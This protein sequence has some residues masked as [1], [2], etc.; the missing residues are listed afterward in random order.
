MTDE[1]RQKLC[2]RLR[3]N[4]FDMDAEEIAADEIEQLAKE[5]EQLRRERDDLNFGRKRV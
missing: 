3:K 5:N 4:G 1:E 2:E